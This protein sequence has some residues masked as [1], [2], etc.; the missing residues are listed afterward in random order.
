MKGASPNTSRLKVALVE[1]QDLTK[2][3]LQNAQPTSFSNRCSSLT[4][5]SVRF[6][7]QIGAWQL[8]DRSRVQPYDGM[9]VWDG[10]TGS[11]ITFDWNQTALPFDRT[12]SKTPGKQ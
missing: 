4:P 7:D 10:V 6:L 5:T 3:T 8:I 1:G 12:K 11:R 9:E 2:T